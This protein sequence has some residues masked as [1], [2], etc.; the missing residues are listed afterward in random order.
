MPN[1]NPTQSQ[2]FLEKRFQRVV[3]EDSCVPQGVTLA[4]KV[5][6]VKLPIGVDAAIRNMGKQKAAW[7][8]EVI[9]LAAL[10]QGLVDEIR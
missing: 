3:D 5:I 1:P 2:E 4:S 9:C 8:R 7:I 10:E 6:S